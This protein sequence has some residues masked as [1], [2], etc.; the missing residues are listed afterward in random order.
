M[1]IHRNPINGSLS[2]SVMR[3][4]YRVC[5]VYYGYTKAEAIREF[6][7]EYGKEE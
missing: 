6:L 5:K 1:S 7:A 2:I 3:G 4:G